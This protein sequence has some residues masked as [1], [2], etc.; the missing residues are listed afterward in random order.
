[1]AKMEVVVAGGELKQSVVR[2]HMIERVSYEDI[3]VT[4][5]GRGDG[6]PEYAVVTWLHVPFDHA[7]DTGGESLIVDHPAGR[8]PLGVY[9]Q[10]RCSI[11]VLDVVIRGR[12]KLPRAGRPVPRTAPSKHEPARQPRHHD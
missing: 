1:M 12:R 11:E 3:G 9:D 5:V 7:A 2:R 8:Q 6:E 4:D 10:V